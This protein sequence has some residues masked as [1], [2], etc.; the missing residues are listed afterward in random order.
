[1]IKLSKN[2]KS[3]KEK[4]LSEETEFSTKYGED[5]EVTKIY[6][7]FKLG[8]E[9]RNFGRDILKGQDD[10]VLMLDY[11][12][13]DTLKDSFLEIHLAA[14]SKSYELVMVKP[15]VDVVENKEDQDEAIALAKELKAIP[16]AKLD[17]NNSAD[18]DFFKKVEKIKEIGNK[19][20]F[21]IE[22]EN[23]ERKLRDD[24]F[25]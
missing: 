13:A 9:A 22:E 4:L 24:H 14:P 5:E 16:A 21:E 19:Y 11:Y 17:K 23:F 8:S 7:K 10:A 3:I 1:M 18:V 12:D 25:R 2:K 15:E 20:G 6:D